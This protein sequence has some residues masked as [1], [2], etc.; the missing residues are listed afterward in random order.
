M[1]EWSAEGGAAGGW[2]KVRVLTWTSCLHF[3]TWTKDKEKEG[4]DRKGSFFLCQCRSWTVSLHVC[5]CFHFLPRFLWRSEQ[6]DS[7]QRPQK[8]NGDDDDRKTSFFFCH[9]NSKSVFFSLLSSSSSLPPTLLS[10]SKTLTGPPVCSGQLP[11]WQRSSRKWGCDWPLRDSAA[12]IRSFNTSRC[13]SCSRLAELGAGAAFRHADARRSRISS[14]LIICRVSCRREEFTGEG[15]RER[16]ERMWSS[17][18]TTDLTWWMKSESDSLDSAKLPA[19]SS[20][21]TDCNFLDLVSASHWTNLRF[22]P[23]GRK[24]HVQSYVIRILKKR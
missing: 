17:M 12:V 9:K 7:L 13:L 4:K 22:S 8:L 11:D 2:T 15:V 21:F 10:V 14:W 23:S 19:H 5:E 16:S 18:K 24:V 3:V 6:L 1:L 20:G